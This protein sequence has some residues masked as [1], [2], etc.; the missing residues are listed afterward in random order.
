VVG[1]LVQ[2]TLVVGLAGDDGGW[3]GG[4]GRWL[5]V[6]WVVGWGR[7]VVGGWPARAAGR[8]A[9]WSPSGLASAQGWAEG[10]QPGKRGG[11]RGRPGP[12]GRQAQELPAGVGQQA[13]GG[14][15]QPGA[16]PF[17]FGH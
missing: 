11:Q 10:P 1:L 13:A 8:R 17:G 5:A 4:L 9:V 6:V 16:Q 3:L 14:V 2:V 12:G 15:Q 7:S